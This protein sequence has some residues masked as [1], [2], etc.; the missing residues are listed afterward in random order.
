MG[1]HAR[2]PADHMSLYNRA[3]LVGATLSATI[4]G[5]LALHGDIAQADGIPHVD[6]GA[7][8]GAVVAGKPQR[9]A[10]GNAVAVERQYLKYLHPEKLTIPPEVSQIMD[11]NVVRWSPI[12]CSGFLIRNP[13]NQP[14]GM[15]TAQHCGLRATG[16]YRTVDAGGNIVLN[17]GVNVF[18]ETGRD[19]NGLTSAGQIGEFALDAPG[20]K[21]MDQA[22]GAFE[23]Q[24][25]QDVIANVPQMSP[26][27]ISQ[28]KT[29]DV[30]Y[31]SGWP[32][33]QPENSGSMERQDFAMTVLGT[34]TITTTD[35]YTLEVVTAAVPEDKDGAECSWGD[36]GSVGI[37]VVAGQPRIVGVLSGFN[38]FGLL[39]HKH[40]PEQGLALKAYYENKFRVNLDG[41]AAVCSFAYLP[42]SASVGGEVFANVAGSSGSPETRPATSIEQFEQQ[43]TSD[44]LNNPNSL[45]QVI[46]GQVQ[47]TGAKGSYAIDKPL[48]T[49]DAKDDLVFLGWRGADGNLQLQPFKQ[50]EL[51]AIS[52][53]SLDG[54]TPPAM[55]WFGGSVTPTGDGAAYVN[56][57][58][59]VFGQFD[60]SA[61][62]TGPAVDGLAVESGTPELEPV[63]SV[64]GEAQDLQAA[65]AQF[66]DPSFD[67]V[68]VNGTTVLHLDDGS[69]IAV[70][71]P[72]L[73]YNPADGNMV[74]GYADQFT[75]QLATVLYGPEAS[76]NFESDEPGTPDFP[77]NIMP[78][79]GNVTFVSGG[80]CFIDDQSTVIGQ[81]IPL[82]NS[83]AYTYALKYEDGQLTFE[84]SHSGVG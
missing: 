17:F 14:I 7:Q 6:R 57:K 69:N 31:S 63:A 45:K 71:D 13:D 80:D 58:G 26:I 11:D 5:N 9:H 47:I 23:G 59:E 24:S 34:Q 50:D 51:G 41:Y 42:P 22:I 77:P 20:D 44:I 65:Q 30:I 16:D 48:I 60:P 79:S 8:A 4:A 25:I 72:Y 78:I 15:I 35:G 1:E 10:I 67:R 74:V 84:P 62:L 75:G 73:Y 52:I 18:A 43:Y 83:A 81:Q 3:L 38:D 49:Y 70:Q 21:T 53:D 39:Y 66:N 61:Q 32:V 2:M 28:L 37:K 40:D 76:L 12:G 54:Q 46:D 19:I 29:G 56:N 33:D 27:E 36:S 82:S 68:F 55:E 64:Q